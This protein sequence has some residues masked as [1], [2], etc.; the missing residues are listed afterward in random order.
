MAREN[1]E[2]LTAGSVRFPQNL[3]TAHD[4]QTARQRLKKDAALDALFQNRLSQLE[5]KYFIDSKLGLL[6]RPATS[7]QEMFREGEGLNH[8]VYSY[9][10][11]HAQGDTAIFLI[12][13]LREPD[14]PYFTLEL[15]EKTLTVRQNRGRSNCS[16]TS[17]V[18]Q[19]E[20]AWLDFIRARRYER[21]ASA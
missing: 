5:D 13:R 7:T 11:R 19:F 8:C 20:K 17:E 14:K 6:I 4:N 18:E 1:G 21:S 16:R 9:R 2:D 15:D 3:K 12:R 10:K